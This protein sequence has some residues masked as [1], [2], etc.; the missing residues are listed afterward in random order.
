MSF[1]LSSAFNAFNAAVASNPS[2]V[3][4][5]ASALGSAISTNG[6]TIGQATQLLQM[7]VS[8]VQT[9][10]T[11]T[12][13]SSK[14]ALVGL[15]SQLPASFNAAFA[16]LADPAIQAD[17]AQFAIESHMASSALAAANSTGLLG[18]LFGKL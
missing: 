18:S 13:G 16:A 5:A 3:A 15:A 4:S 7:F 8:A 1:N 10:D 11:A 14:I 9:K 2:G 6:A 17:P 12:A